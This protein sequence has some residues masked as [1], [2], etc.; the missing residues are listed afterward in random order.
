MD[1]NTKTPLQKARS[2]YESKRKTKNISFNMTTENDLYEFAVSMDFG[3]WV[4][5]NLRLEMKKKGKSTK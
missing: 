2:R 1:N 4:K 3:E 5:E